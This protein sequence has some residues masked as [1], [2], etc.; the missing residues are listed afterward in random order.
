MKK[1]FIGLGIFFLTGLGI[2]F[3]FN[4]IINSEQ[5][6][7]DSA[8][9]IQS[10]DSIPQVIS[11]LKDV[12]N[13]IEALKKVIKF[14]KYTKVKA[15]KYSLKQ[16]MT[17]NEIINL[18]RSGNQ[19]PVKVTFNNQ[20][21]IENLA[22]RLAQQIEADSTSIVNSL[23]DKNFLQKHGFTYKTAINYCMPYTYDCY[24]NITPNQLRTK[25]FNAYLRFWNK[26]RL[27]KAHRL[28]LTT[29]EVISLA[30]IVHKETQNKPERKKVAGVYLNRIRK[31]IP[32]QADP[33]IIYAIKEQQ[34]RETIIKRVL[35]KDLKIESSYNTYTHR[36]IPPS[37]IAMPD[38]DA[39]DAVLNAE[40]HAYYYFCVNPEKLGTHKFAKTLSQHNRNA[41]AYHK[42]LRK[43]RINR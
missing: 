17:S 39:I 7:K 30:A 26:T 9:Y 31:G 38:V 16:G 18:L 19:T 33:T 40:R 35:K 8:I 41:S 25:L 4:S 27:K 24:W 37:A 36:G 20:N 3:Y 1:I 21:Y 43:Q 42:W 5:V 13:D 34:G 28:N 15:G 11:H 6:D 23:L 32:L 10:T 12:C 2:V 22:G 29:N 14:K